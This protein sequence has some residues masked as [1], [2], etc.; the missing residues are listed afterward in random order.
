[1]TT[2]RNPSELLDRYLQAV[3]FWLPKSPR[4]KT[5]CSLNSAKIYAHRLKHAR[6]NSAI[7]LTK[8]KSQP[9]SSAAERPWL[10]PPVWGRSVT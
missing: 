10:S 1:M 4:G 7:L 5:I 9:S 8:Q 2:P 3:R 6:A